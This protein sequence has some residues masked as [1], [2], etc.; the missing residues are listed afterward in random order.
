MERFYTTKAAL[1]LKLQSHLNAALLACSELE[2]HEAGAPAGEE[3]YMFS[4]FATLSELHAEVS[5]EVDAAR[6][7]V[8]LARGEV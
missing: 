2:R 3:G 8:K 1:L 4:S 6:A 7:M 5:G